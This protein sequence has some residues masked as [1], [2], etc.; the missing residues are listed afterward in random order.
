MGHMRLCCIRWWYGEAVFRRV[1]N[2]VRFQRPPLPDR[3]HS[4]L[5]PM[6]NSPPRPT[7]PASTNPLIPHR[8]W[9]DAG[10]LTVALIAAAVALFANLIVACWTNY[11]TRKDRLEQRAE[12]CEGLTESLITAATLAR[13][14]AQAAVDVLAE[15]IPAG[16][17]SKRFVVEPFDEILHSHAPLM[18]IID[19]DSR[20]VIFRLEAY[21]RSLRDDLSHTDDV[22]AEGDTFSL[23]PGSPNREVY[24]KLF[25]LLAQHGTAAVNISADKKHLCDRR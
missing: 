20:S 19:P 4:G 23:R 1:L 25:G 24:R 7:P 9:R 6:D 14:T 8:N 11:L 17:S 3:R 16:Q 13:E 10:P 12:Q 15:P 22:K 21:Y 2:H 5:C 18:Y